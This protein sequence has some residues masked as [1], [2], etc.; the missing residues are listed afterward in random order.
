MPELRTQIFQEGVHS[1]LNGAGDFVAP[2]GSQYNSRNKTQ[3]TDKNLNFLREIPS[4]PSLSKVGRTF[5]FSGKVVAAMAKIRSGRERGFSDKSG[6]RFR[7]NDSSLYE[8][9][10][11]M[12]PCVIF[13]R[14][15]FLF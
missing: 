5:P 9:M 3:E 15:S 7:I 2:A 1:P 4:V 11:F 8:R 6:R 14:E 13:F 12:S 10:Q